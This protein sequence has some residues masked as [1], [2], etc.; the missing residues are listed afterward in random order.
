MSRFTPLDASTF[1]PFDTFISPASPQPSSPVLE[2][3]D[4]E[5]IQPDDNC[6]VL[7]TKLPADIKYPEVFSALAEF[8]LGAIFSARILPPARQFRTAAAEVIFFEP[9]GAQTLIRVA[10]A[11][12]RGENRRPGFGAFLVRGENVHVRPSRR[13]VGPYIGPLPASRVLVVEGPEGMMNVQRLRALLEFK[14]GRLDTVSTRQD[15]DASQG[16]VVV[17]WEFAGYKQAETARRVVRGA[18]RKQRK[19]RAR[20]GTDYA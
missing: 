13:V 19:V 12:G 10:A 16:V 18:F 4:P 15:G 17:T 8:R 20:F 11:T 9:A 3:L 7:I 2:P 5:L 6:A 14:L 1:I